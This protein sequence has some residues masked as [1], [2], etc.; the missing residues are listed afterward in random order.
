MHYNIVL[1]GILLLFLLRNY[2]LGR[3]FGQK[4]VQVVAQLFVFS[5]ISAMAGFAGAGE[6]SILTPTVTDAEILS[7]NKIVNVVVKVT[8]LSD[9]DKLH[10]YSEKN[11]RSYDPDGRYEKDGIY[12][13]HYS[14]HLNKGKNSFIL[15]PPKLPIKL[16]YTPFGTLL[17][18]NFEKSGVYLFHRQEV[19][20]SPCDGCH[21]KKMAVG[22]D[23][24]PAGYGQSS[25]EC[26]SCHQSTT[27]SAEWQH[28]PAASLFCRACHG[29]G[30]GLT[31]VAVPTSN[32]EKV[33]L[34]CHVNHKK[35]LDMEHVHGPVGTGDCTI[36][37]DPHGGNNRYQLWA[38]GKA[39]LCVI[40]H[41]DKKKYVATFPRQKLKVHGIL[42]AR[43]CVACHSPHADNYRFQLSS[44]TNDLCASCHI[45]F[46]GMEQGHPAQG[47]P[48]KGVEDPLR[49]GVPMSCASCHDP[50][51]SNYAYLLVGDSRG[52]L[53][54]AKC[55]SRRKKKRRF[56]R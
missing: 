1:G 25:P 36:C 12:Y 23:A 6:I 41:E 9:L 18:V 34:G 28:S 54:C 45:E 27:L 16:K 35:L 13:V 8:D 29:E 20:P 5:V 46:K 55:H 32:V 31:K 42:T 37:H 2:W 30:A 38:D 43:G 44:K 40:C 7:R 3:F 48:V 51:G 22:T 26:Y 21:D 10:L 47:H 50:H 17:N 15:E 53:V 33:C 11:E 4:S 56:G 19:I 49:P 24:N 39:K 52:G 14:L